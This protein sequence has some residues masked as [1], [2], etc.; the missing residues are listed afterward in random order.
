MLFSYFLPRMKRTLRFFFSQGAIYAITLNPKGAR[1]FENMLSACGF[2]WRIKATHAMLATSE[3][4]PLLCQL[5][6]CYAIRP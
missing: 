1:I 2:G 5:L 6:R 4:L 3:T